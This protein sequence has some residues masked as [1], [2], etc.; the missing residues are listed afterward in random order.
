MGLYVPIFPKSKIFYG[1]EENY[2]TLS[3][4]IDES[5]IRK[6]RWD[7]SKCGIILSDGRNISPVRYDYLMGA[8]SP[9]EILERDYEKWENHYPIW[10]NIIYPVNSDEVESFHLAWVGLMIDSENAVLPEIKFQKASGWAF[11][12]YDY[13]SAQGI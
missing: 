2:L 1:S 9:E 4:A 7:I 6:L 12:I 10:V 13:G 11:T 3:V 5:V 8:H